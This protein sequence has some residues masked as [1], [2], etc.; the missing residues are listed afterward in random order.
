M[1]AQLLDPEQL[2]P[3]RAIVRSI[4]L[5]GST[6][7][8]ARFGPAMRRLG[9]PA[10]ASSSS[11]CESL[12]ARRWALSAAGLKGRDDQL[13]G[14][15]AGQDAERLSRLAA[16][17]P[18]ASSRP[19]IWLRSRSTATDMPT[20]CQRFQL[21]DTSGLSPAPRPRSRANVEE[22]VGRAVVG[23]ADLGQDRVERRAQQHEVGLVVAQ[24]L[25]EH[26]RAGIFGASTRSHI[27]GVLS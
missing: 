21:T 4:G 16:L 10:E 20:P 2:L 14:G 13:R 12:K 11:D 25:L 9:Q 17:M 6:K 27:A 3:D 15:V 8:V 24:Q 19:V 22:R 7:A 23:L 1:H 5:A 18:P 26:Q